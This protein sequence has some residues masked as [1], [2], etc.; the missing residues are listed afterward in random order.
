MEQKIVR[1][2]KMTIKQ[3]LGDAKVTRFAQVE[4]GR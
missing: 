4:V 1:D 3:L 2:P